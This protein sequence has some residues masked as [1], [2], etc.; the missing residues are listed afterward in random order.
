MDTL[1]YGDKV[2]RLLPMTVCL[3]LIVLINL[4]IKAELS[5]NVLNYYHIYEMHRLPLRE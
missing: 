3:H 2:V 4:I 5:P 1:T